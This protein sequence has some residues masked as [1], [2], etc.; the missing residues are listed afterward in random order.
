MI[1]VIEKLVNG[2]WVATSNV[3]LSRKQI[4]YVLDR[5]LAHGLK[6]RRVRIYVPGVSRE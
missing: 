5:L 6:N 3:R 4:D 1:Y 2:K